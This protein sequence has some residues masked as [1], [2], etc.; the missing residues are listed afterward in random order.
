[1][2]TVDA[3][4]LLMHTSVDSLDA[5]R[6]GG[7]QFTTTTTVGEGQ[8]M[9]TSVD[10]LELDLAR[11][12]MAEGGDDEREERDSLE[13]VGGQMSNQEELEWQ[14]Q[15]RSSHELGVQVL[16]IPTSGGNGNGSPSATDPA[17]DDGSERTIFETVRI[18]PTD[19]SAERL[20]RTA[21]TRVRD[22]IHSR[23][24]FVGT[25]VIA[26]K[27]KNYIGAILKDEQQV[28]AILD[29]SGGEERETIDEEGNVTR[30]RTI[31]E[32]NH[33]FVH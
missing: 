11:K 6:V 32:R 3:S 9:E 8:R 16:D 5:E 10:S 13:E 15:R 12:E 29:G 26:K 20:I 2:I 17:D 14:K 24:R 21:I 1:V 25:E 4:P 19:G 27:I 23:V 30:V 31:V 18:N 33:P 7:T 28:Q 22:P